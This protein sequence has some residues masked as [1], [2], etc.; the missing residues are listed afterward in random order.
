ML[1]LAAKYRY[2]QWCERPAAVL[3]NMCTQM[4]DHVLAHA[5]EEWVTYPHQPCCQLLYF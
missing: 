4:L 2:V 3:T 1:L 5:A